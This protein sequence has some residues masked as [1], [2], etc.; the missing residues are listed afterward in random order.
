MH[1]PKGTSGYAPAIAASPTT[2]GGF[3][4]FG[5]AETNGDYGAVAR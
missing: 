3:S 1:T 5:V 4:A 2:H